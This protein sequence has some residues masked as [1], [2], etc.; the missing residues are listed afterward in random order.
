MERQ[1]NEKRKKN[2]NCND[3]IYTLPVELRI[4]EREEDEYTKKNR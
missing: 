4:M 1:E 2:N 3:D